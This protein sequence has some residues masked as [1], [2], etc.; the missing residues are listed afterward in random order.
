MIVMVTFRQI[1]CEPAG[2]IGLTAGLAIGI[3]IYIKLRQDKMKILWQDEDANQ[4]ISL[5]EFRMKQRKGAH[6]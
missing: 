6:G 2:R 4:T 1:I 3:I 5:E